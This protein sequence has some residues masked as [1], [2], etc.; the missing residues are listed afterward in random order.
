MEKIEKKVTS[1]V[2]T[3]SRKKET[4]SAELKTNLIPHYGLMEVTTRKL[5]IKS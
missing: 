5:L 4:I 3:Q 2:L 1:E